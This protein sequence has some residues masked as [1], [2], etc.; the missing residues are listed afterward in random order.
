ML[1][2]R[3][4]FL[5]IGTVLVLLALY[6]TDPDGGASTGILVLGI[7][8]GVIA[9]AIAHL[10]RKALM[11]Y[12]E[13]DMRRLFARA[14]ESPTGA[15]LAL[16]AIAIVLF[17]LLGLFGKNV[18]AATVD[19]RT[20]VPK[21]AVLYA[22]TLDRERSAFWATHP[23]PRFLGGLIEQ[24]SCIS[25]THSRCWSPA[26]RL[27]TAR[28]EGAGLGQITRAYRA[29]GGLR[30][31][32][33]TEAVRRHPELRGWN[34]ENVYARPDLQLRSIVLTSRENYSR[35][36]QL[37]KDPIAS[38]HFAD[39]AYNGGFGGMMSDRRACGL[40]RGCDPQVWFGATELTCTKS[41]VAI[42][43][44]RSACIINRE[45]VTNVFRLRSEKYRPLLEKS[46]GVAPVSVI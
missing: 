2:Y 28:E 26:S 5:A 34:W 35:I 6:L 22:P 11:D 3:S 42:Y 20:F 4:L 38:L 25:L 15:G 39:A 40:K 17:G 36:H 37:V 23:A 41:R 10:C 18:H 32:A 44:T 7:T 21:N 8:T 13:A 33:L 43:G 45:H 24:E 31:D 16:V 27:K 19:A 30:F 1:R 12:G 46:L 9:V 14:G 29:D